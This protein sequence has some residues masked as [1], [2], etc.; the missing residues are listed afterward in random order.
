MRLPALLAA[1]CL[2]LLVLAPGADAAPSIR[3]GIQDDAWL[4]NGPGS[5][6]QRLNRLDALGVDLVRFTIEWN[7]VEQTQGTFDWRRPDTVL[8]GLHEHGIAAV[9]TLVGSPMWANGG[10][11]SNWAPAPATFA[12]FA[13]AAALRY[14]FVRDWLIWNE[15][16]QARWLRPTSPAVYVRQILNPAY[17]A[18][19]AVRRNARVAG[20]VTAPRGSTG[21]VSP[22]AWIRGM[23]KAGARL[24]VYAHHPYPSNPRIESPSSGGCGHCDTITMATLGRLLTEVSQA[25][26]PKRIWLTEYGYQTNPPDRIL[27][28]STALQARYIGD[29]AY[30]A[31]RFPR[32]DMLVHYL[33]VDESDPARFQSG[34]YTFA[35]KPKAAAGAFA[36]PLAQTGRRGRVVT[37]WGQVRPGTGPQ[38]YRIEVRRGQVWRSIGGA[39]RT[40]PRG[41]FSARVTLPPGATVRA[42]SGSRTF[43]GAPQ[44]IR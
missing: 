30:R 27:G 6:E 35:G 3:F 43:A 4:L 18:I 12:G 7:Q 25:F 2:A 1:A 38:T 11:P 31:Y 32:V 41:Y 42:I 9:V 28:I 15:P 26:G 39:R 23:K 44:R 33:V 29:A 10:R 17:A 5:L 13:R 40:S 22:V 8:Q 24:D 19:H 14:P 20:G 16:N 34:L 21:G 37:L 36:V